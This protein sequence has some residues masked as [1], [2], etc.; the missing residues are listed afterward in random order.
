MHELPHDVIKVP[1]RK[2]KKSAG[3]A[4][5]ADKSWRE[6]RDIAFEWPINPLPPITTIFIR[7]SFL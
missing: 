6:A 3:L 4:S 1:M 2:V 5:V 7:D